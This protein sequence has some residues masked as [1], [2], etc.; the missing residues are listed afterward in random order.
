[1]L[2]AGT[3]VRVWWPLDDAWYGGEILR[4]DPDTNEHTILY[5]DGVEESIDLSKEKAEAVLPGEEGGD[6]PTRAPPLAGNQP[7]RIPVACGDR[8]G[9]LLPNPR[10]GREMV[11]YDLDV[12]RTTTV[13]AVEFNN[14]FAGDDAGKIK[15]WRRTLRFDPTRA[16]ERWKA[17]GG[18]DKEVSI[19]RWLAQ[20]GAVWG[21]AAVGRPLKLRPADWTREETEKE[22]KTN[23]PSEDDR[24]ETEKEAKTNELS[25]DDRDDDVSP[26]ETRGA[27]DIVQVDVEVL[28]STADDARRGDVTMR[29]AASGRRGR[30]GGG[31]GVGDGGTRRRGAEWWTAS[32]VAFNEQTGE[33]QVLF[34][35]GTREWMSI[36]AQE[37]KPG[38]RRRD[39][40]R[41]LRILLVVTRRMRPRGRSQFSPPAHDRCARTRRDGREIDPSRRARLAET[42]SPVV[43]RVVK[44]RKL[45]TRVMPPSSTPS[46]RDLRAVLSSRDG[47]LD[48]TR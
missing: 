11:S 30:G 18:C 5:Y 7:E 1:M 28:R 46:P 45:A 27:A 24:E 23:E 10:R 48:G 20:Q 15:R 21:E 26:P 6:A 42:I 3:Q 36:V 38:V 41:S 35:D 25:E 14:L 2:P 12:G 39:R 31:G 19:G 32:V 44:T 4:H 40:E 47:A 8:R 43:A 29:D 37:T 13:T 16:S 33:H 34:T 17:K 9:W 22:A